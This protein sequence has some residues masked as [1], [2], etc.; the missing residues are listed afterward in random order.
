MI[1]A[2]A[3]V[4]TGFSFDGVN[5]RVQAPN[6]A[7][8][9]LTTAVTMDAWIYPT[10]FTAGKSVNA[11]VTKSDSLNGQRSYGMWIT[12]A[13]A[14]LLRE[15]N[16]QFSEARGPHCVVLS[17]ERGAPALRKLVLASRDPW[18]ASGLF[19]STLSLATPGGI[20]GSRPLRSGP[21][22]SGGARRAGGPLR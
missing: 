9:N 17:L 2:P 14:V 6:S 22:W 4:G 16:G 13:G 8:L 3:K 18:S 5:G 10:A 20:V 21:W 19:L 12:S 1:F 11:V 7:S 15:F